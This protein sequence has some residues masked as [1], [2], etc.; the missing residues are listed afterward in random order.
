MALLSNPIGLRE[1]RAHVCIDFAQG[2]EAKCVQM[3][4][5][6]KSFDPAKARMLETPRQNDVTIHPVLPND[7]GSEA[8]A[9]LECNSRFLGQPSP[10]HFVL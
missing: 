9:H 10:V 7:E 8:H 6:R 5:R 2:G 4:P 3:V 1:P